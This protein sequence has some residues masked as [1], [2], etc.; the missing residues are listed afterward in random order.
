MTNIFF[1]DEEWIGEYQLA[2]DCIEVNK[3]TIY[4][5]RTALIKKEK[6][7]NFFERN[8]VYDE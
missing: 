4:A 8:V 1:D 6:Y 3:S 2:A 5:V 7:I